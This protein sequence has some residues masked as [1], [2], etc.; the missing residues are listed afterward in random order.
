M[1]T[2]KVY[3]VRFKLPVC[4]SVLPVHSLDDGACLWVSAECVG[5]KVSRVIIKA[6]LLLYQSSLE[7]KNFVNFKETQLFQLVIN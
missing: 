1:R 2:F 6:A 5:P 7:R 4:I 3:K